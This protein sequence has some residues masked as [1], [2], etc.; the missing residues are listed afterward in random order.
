MANGW[1]CHSACGDV[2]LNESS[3][4]HYD[5]DTTLYPAELTDLVLYVSNRNLA[6]QCIAR[7]VYAP[8]GGIALLVVTLQ[9]CNRTVFAELA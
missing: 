6:S 3:L 5:L 2:D 4:E 9:K 1:V 8:A 7:N